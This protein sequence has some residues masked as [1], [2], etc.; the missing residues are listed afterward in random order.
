MLISVIFINYMSDFSFFSSVILWE[1]CQISHFPIARGAL[2]HLLVDVAA[3]QSQLPWL[4]SLSPIQHLHGLQSPSVLELVWQSPAPHR[5][6]SAWITPYSLWKIHR[7]QWIHC[8]PVGNTCV[9]WSQLIRVQIGACPQMCEVK[10]LNIQSCEIK[11]G[12][13]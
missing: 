7:N 6:I 3:G 2:P 8:I 1:R 12:Q 13:V 10:W 4:Q 5:I 11:H 9:N